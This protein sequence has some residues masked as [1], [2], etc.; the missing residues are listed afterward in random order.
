MSAGHINDPDHWRKRAAE[1]RA[2]ADGMKDSDAKQTMLRIAADY[3]KL[4]ERAML[5]SDGGK[6]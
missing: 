3:D 1:M 5:R 6:H 2:L 4:A